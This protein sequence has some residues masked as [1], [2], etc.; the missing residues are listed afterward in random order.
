MIDSHILSKKT[1]KKENRKGLDCPE[2]LILCFF[3]H[4]LLIFSTENGKYLQ[5]DIP[6]IE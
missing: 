4:G 3:C 2:F 6:V 1:N 5:K